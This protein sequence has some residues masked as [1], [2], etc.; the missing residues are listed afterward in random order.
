MRA[1]GRAE[2]SPIAPATGISTPPNTM[3]ENPSM[4]EALPAFLPQLSRA[5]DV[6][7]APSTDNGTMAI[8]RE[9]MLYQSG[10]ESNTPARN[11]TAPVRCPHRAARSM[12][13]PLTVPDSLAGRAP[14]KSSPSPIKP[15]I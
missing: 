2:F 4:A 10:A 15:K 8:N 5:I 13:A 3:E 14:I 7:E 6:E 1:I 11:R 12:D 9:T